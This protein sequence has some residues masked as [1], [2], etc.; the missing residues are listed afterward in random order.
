MQLIG[1]GNGGPARARGGNLTAQRG[2]RDRRF[3]VGVYLGTV[4]LCW[5]LSFVLP[6]LLGFHQWFMSGDV[7]WTTQSA[8]WVSHGAVGTV[9]EA[10]PWFSALPGFLILYAPVT[11]LG[12]H[13]GLVTG[14]PFPVPHP[15]M[16]LVGGPFFFLTGSSCVLGVDRLATTLQIPSRRRK[17]VLVVLAVLVVAPTPGLAGHPEDMLAM[18]ILCFSVSMYLEG[19]FAAAGYLLAS[20]V[21]IQTW[22]GLAVPLLVLAAPVGERLRMLVRSSALPGLTAALLV[23]LDFRPAVTDL[24]RQP[25]VNS[26]Q[27]LPWWSIAGHMTVTDGWHKVQVVVGSSSRWMA[28]L[29]AL[30]TALSVRRRNS[31]QQILAGLSV[32]MLARGVFETEF[33]DYYLAPATVLLVLLVAMTT[34]ARPYK[35]AAGTVLALIP[36]V[37]WPTAYVGVSIDPLIAETVL[38]ASGIVAVAIGLDRGWRAGPL[39]NGGLELPDAEERGLPAPVLTHA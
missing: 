29:V 24:L 39:P 31:P 30:A 19:R 32:V 20:A 18:A 17:L 1:A 13:L 33:W 8:Q 7:W 28:V 36:A 37:A 12:D 34:T 5:F 38:L 9:Y 22:A 25:M 23:A 4:V 14:Y 35:W 2:W 6:D 15:S 27:K 26:G 11:A 21:M 16:W 3:A 10:N